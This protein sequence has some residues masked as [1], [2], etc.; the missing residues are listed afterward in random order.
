MGSMDTITGKRDVERNAREAADRA[1]GT[2]IET[3]QEAD[4]VI[5]GL[6]QSIGA[7]ELVRGAY[8]AM[9]PTMWPETSSPRELVRRWKFLLGLGHA[10]I[11]VTGHEGPKFEGP[12][13][14]PTSGGNELHDAVHLFIVSLEAVILEEEQSTREETG[15]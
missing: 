13:R 3:M 5:R 8:G 10:A 11:Q 1:R 2:R 9:A 15:K 7:R 12:P 6:Q 14:E 4:A